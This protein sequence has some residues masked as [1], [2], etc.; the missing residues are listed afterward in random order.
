MEESC[1]LVC[2]KRVDACVGTDSWAEA[3]SEMLP[4][5]GIGRGTARSDDNIYNVVMA[6]I[7]RIA[8]VESCVKH[9]TS[10]ALSLSSTLS[11]KGERDSPRTLATVDF[12]L[13]N[14]RKSA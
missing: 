13:H 12:Q 2:G 6:R 11:C 4:G 3:E 10:S 9:V 8:L 7:E 1:A 5:S 14:H